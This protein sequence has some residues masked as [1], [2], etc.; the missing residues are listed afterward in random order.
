MKLKITLLAAL[1]LAVSVAPQASAGPRG[2]A[3]RTATAAC[4][5]ELRALGRAEF[6]ATYGRHAIRSCVRAHLAE[7]AETVRNAAE[8]C[9]AERD[10]DRAAFAEAYGRNGNKRNAF[11]RCVASK[12]RAEVAEEAREVRNAAQ[13]CREERRAD[14]EA[15]AVTYGTNG[16]RRN[17]FGKCVSSKA[18]DADEAP[19]GEAPAETPAP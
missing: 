9:R 6:A 18:G 12:L 16:N 13:A 1:V 10:A 17:A 5:A 2:L 3:H 7:A 14:P 4:K 15:F 11:G 19:A 8:E